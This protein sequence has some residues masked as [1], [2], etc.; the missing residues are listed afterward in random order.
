ML[1]FNR[2][3]NMFKRFELLVGD[4]FEEIKNKNILVIGVGG[5]GS[6]VV[7]SLVRCG[8]ENITIVDNDIVD[9][10]NLNRQLMTNLNN[11][12]LKKVDV[13][14]ER[15]NSINKD[16]IVCTKDI[17]VSEENIDDIITNFDYVVDAV[18][19]IKA[20]LAIIKCCFF[21]KIKLI[22][23][24]GM[25]GRMNPSL[26]EITD[27]YKTSYDPL[28]KIMRYNLRK[29]GI[30][31]LTVVCSC[32][33]IKKKVKGII[34]SNSFVPASAGLLITSYIINDIVGGCDV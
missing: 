23:S 17:L 15:I 16:C 14:K 11:I 5:V 22:S 21:K 2:D 31:K 7:E 18:D 12:G 32:E 1:Q 3:D 4:K 34:P 27:I 24:M 19:D 29:M 28:A 9:I 10:T 25:G 13:L 6:Y 33:K 26:L 20:K 8:I 30:K